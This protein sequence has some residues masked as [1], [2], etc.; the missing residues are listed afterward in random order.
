MADRILKITVNGAEQYL[1]ESVTLLN[2]LRAA[3][4]AGLPPKRWGHYIISYTYADN[5][6]VWHQLLPSESARI[7][8]DMYVEVQPPNKRWWEFWK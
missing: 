4:L 3:N 8:N 1:H 5:V 2:H 6:G 7:V